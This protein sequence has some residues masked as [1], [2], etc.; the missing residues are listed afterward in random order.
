MISVKTEPSNVQIIVKRTWSDDVTHQTG[1]YFAHYSLRPAAAGQP[2]RIF[3]VYEDPGQQFCP[4][5]G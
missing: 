4:R 5:P 2:F 3:G 1:D